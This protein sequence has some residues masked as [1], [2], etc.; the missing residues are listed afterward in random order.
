[1]SGRQEFT[2]LRRF[3]VAKQ[4]CTSD[5]FN[6]FIRLLNIFGSSHESVHP[7]RDLELKSM[8]PIRYLGV[9]KLPSVV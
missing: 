4:Y 5:M 9:A 1:M 8:S 6:Y 3:C 2:V 7:E